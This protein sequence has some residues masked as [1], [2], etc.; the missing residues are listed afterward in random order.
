[1]SNLLTHIERSY[2]L[3]EPT[4]QRENQ[5]S[6]ETTKYARRPFFVDQ[7]QITAENMAAVAE[8]CQ[9]EVR[10]ET[11]ADGQEVAYVHV[12]VHR[13]L[14]ERQTKGYVGDHVLYAGTGYKVYTHKAFEASFEKVVEEVA[15]A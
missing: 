3:T 2:G 10:T 12:R 15:V 8:W 14:N 11:G 4:T 1:M 9:G 7:V 5:M 6:I 13:P